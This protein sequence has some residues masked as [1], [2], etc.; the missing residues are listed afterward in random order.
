MRI[1]FRSSDRPA[2]CVR[3]NIDIVIKYFPFVLT[4]CFEDCAAH[5]LAQVD[6]THLYCPLRGSDALRYSPALGEYCLEGLRQGFKFQSCRA[7]V[8]IA[9]DWHRDPAGLG[10]IFKRCQR[11][12]HRPKILL[13]TPYGIPNR[14]R[15]IDVLK[16]LFA[17]TV[18]STSSLGTAIL[19]NCPISII[20]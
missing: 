20:F 12:T 13:I 9:S 2:P 6:R 17:I 1:G 10:A 4:C 3:L 18:F 7:N 14:L 11:P 19:G 16:S 5:A 8:L 15:I